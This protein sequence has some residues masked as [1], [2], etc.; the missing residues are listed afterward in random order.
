VLGF[1]WADPGCKFYRHCR[2]P[3]GATALDSDAVVHSRLALAW[4]DQRTVLGFAGPIPAVSFIAIAE[5][6]PSRTASATL[7]Y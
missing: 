5:S 2:I 3:S 1:A 4:H 6:P 7:R